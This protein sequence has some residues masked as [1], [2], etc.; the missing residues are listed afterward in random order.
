M[1]ALLKFDSQRRTT[2]EGR[3]ETLQQITRRLAGPK[4]MI[5]ESPWA[6]LQELTNENGSFCQ[7][8][9]PSQA[10]SAST[11]IDLYQDA[12]QLKLA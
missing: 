2:P 10:W 7:D 3:V 8:S 1:R 4:R 6:G 11:L 12:A 5:K 9:C